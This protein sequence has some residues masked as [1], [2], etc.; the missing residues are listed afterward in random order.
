[1][2]FHNRDGAYATRHDRWM[3]L[4]LFA[5]QLTEMG[6]RRMRAKSLRKT[7]VDALINRWQTE[8][9]GHTG[10]PLTA[11]TLKN[12]AIQPTLVGGEDK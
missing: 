3:Q 8:V 9:S 1:M 10:Q 5:K 2:V 11:K 7:H 4:Q 6:Y 12:S